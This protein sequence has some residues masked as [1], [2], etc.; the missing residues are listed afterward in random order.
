[1]DK[2]M[3]REVMDYKTLQWLLD[4]NSVRDIIIETVGI[5]EE[6]HEGIEDAEGIMATVIEEE[7]VDREDVVGVE[8]DSVVEAEEAVCHMM[9]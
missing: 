7:G 1:M 3:V 9:E 2:E 8:V 4:I 6:D 5:V